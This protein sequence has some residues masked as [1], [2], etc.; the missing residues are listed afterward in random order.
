[1]HFLDF[2]GFQGQNVYGF[3]GIILLGIAFFI[4]ACFF[5]GSDKD[6]LTFLSIFLSGACLVG[7]P[8]L[9]I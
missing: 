7:L 9:F 8:A 3:L 4:L 1:M 2:L 5:G 6:R